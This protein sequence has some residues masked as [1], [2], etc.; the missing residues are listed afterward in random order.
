MDKVRE[1]TELNY[2][3][4]GALEV[5]M[6]LMTIVHDICYDSHKYTGNAHSEMTIRQHGEMPTNQEL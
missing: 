5:K 1:F 3:H 6:Y 2:K 4:Y